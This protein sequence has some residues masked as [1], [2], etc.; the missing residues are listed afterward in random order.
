MQHRMPKQSTKSSGKTI[1][2]RPGNTL[3]SSS[4][5]NYSS[6]HHHTSQAC[7]RFIDAPTDGGFFPSKSV[8]GSPLRRITEPKQLDPF[9][10]VLS[11]HTVDVHAGL[12]QGLDGAVVAVPCSQVK[13]GVPATMAGHEIGVGV[14]QHA[15][16]LHTKRSRT[17]TSFAF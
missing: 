2:Q 15:H 17:D 14:D 13:R 9:I 11:Y 10:Y 6:L 1:L 7:P 8:R 12:Q 16:H 3:S 4:P 5:I